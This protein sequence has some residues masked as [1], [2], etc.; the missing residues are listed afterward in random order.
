MKKKFQ[1][2]ER[3]I[4]EYLQETTNI[5]ELKDDYI[6]KMILSNSSSNSI[7]SLESIVT[8]FSKFVLENIG[9][10]YLDDVSKIDSNIIN[11]YIYHLQYVQGNKGNTIN[12]KLSRLHSMFKNGKKSKIIKVNPLEGYI[13][14]KTTEPEKKTI[15]REELDKVLKNLDRRNFVECRTYF[16]IL[17]QYH[18]GCR[19]GEIWMAD[20]EDFNLDD[21]TWHIPVT[22]N[23]K[24]R[25]VPLPDT[26]VKE[27]CFWLAVR[28]S[29]SPTTS[30]LMVT[31]EGLHVRQAILERNVKKAFVNVGMNDISTH[32]LRHTFCSRMVNDKG[33]P[34]NVLSAIVGTSPH[35]L[36]KN[37]IHTRFEDAKKYME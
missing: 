21:K 16:V 34:V 15:S 36:Y 2:D 30:K 29:V 35:V 31:I 11:E 33:M 9:K 27:L 28:N 17:F 18:V 1:I 10:D 12:Y 4:E 3:L 22:K 13:R 37:Y 25:T 24:P 7:R 8:D 20:V 5:W 32:N 19:I 14:Q 23:R 26:I 6:Q